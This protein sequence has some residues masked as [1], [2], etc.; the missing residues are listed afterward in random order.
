MHAALTKSP[1]PRQQ[2]GM[3]RV[4]AA[5]PS[6]RAVSA[7]GAPIAPR[8]LRRCS[9]GG[10]CPSC[11]AEQASSTPASAI[12]IGHANDPAER[13]A[14]RV[15]DS[16]ASGT[17]RRAPAQAAPAPTSVPASVRATLGSS[18]RPLD[19]PVRADM[20]ARLGADFQHVR[21]HTDAAA[22]ASAREIDASAYT[23]GEHVVFAAGEYAPATESGR[24]LI[25]HELAH[26]IQDGAASGVLRRWPGD[27][28]K[29][30]GDCSW[31]EYIALKIAVDLAKA[32]FSA[33]GGCKG[34]DSCAVLLA[35]IAAVS[36]EIA[37]RLFLMV[38]CFKGGDAD[39]RE[40]L[41][42]KVNALINCYEFFAKN[43]CLRKLAEE[44]AAAAAALAAA[45]AAAAKS[46]AE[47]EEALEAAEEAAIEVEEEATLG[48]VLEG[49]LIL[50]L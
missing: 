49:I 29:P 21:V 1:D 46:A 44:A 34:T 38:K 32:A 24:W 48:E 35:K 10:G 22:G 50:A 36:A 3:R 11:R 41:N 23:M 19:A 13:E 5:A 15:A 9:C 18:G 2:T 12:A 39:H 30:P 4:A 42:N 8:T 7:M 16:I 43:D 40:Q 31:A 14:E 26:V 47:A 25:A 33:L 45:R 20:E 27:G 17:V 37:A 28:M 6:R